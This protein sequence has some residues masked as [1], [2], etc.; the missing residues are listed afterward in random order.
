LQKFLSERK[1]P[2]TFKLRKATFKGKEM[3]A[4]LEGA[5]WERFRDKAYEG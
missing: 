2:G 3:Q 5:F 4:D 1:R